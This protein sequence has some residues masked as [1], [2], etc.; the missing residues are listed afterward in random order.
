ML[1]NRIIAQ[2]FN[3]EIV[4]AIYKE[5]AGSN[6]DI[7]EYNYHV[8]IL[9]IHY[10]GGSTAFETLFPEFNYS[11]RKGIMLVGPVGTGK[12]MIMENFNKLCSSVYWHGR[13]F[14]Q[15]DIRTVAKEYIQTGNIDRFT[16]NPQDTQGM[17]YKIRPANYCFDDLGTEPEIIK[18]YGNDISPAIELLLDRYNIFTKYHKVTHI[19]TNLSPESITQR[20]GERISS[21]MREMFNVIHVLGNDRRK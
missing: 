11:L 15:I 5:I 19:T 21:R 10:F 7:D 18:N 20:Y 16:I 8:I 3:V 4:L 13:N 17:G 2:N 1:E 14:K 9:L 6:Y 12:T